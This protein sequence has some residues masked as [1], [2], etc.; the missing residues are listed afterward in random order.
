MPPVPIGNELPVTYPI[1]IRNLGTVA[2]KYTID[3]STLEK[4]NRK[5]HEFTIFK[6]LNPNGTLKPQE[7]SHVY[8]NFNPLEENLYSLDLPI[9]V[10]DIDGEQKDRVVLKIR[11][12]GYHHVDKI[13]K[14]E[15]FYENMP[16]CRAHLSEEA[17]AM[18]AFSMES[19]DFGELEANEPSRRF[20]VLYNIDHTDK[21]SFKFAETGLTY[22]DKLRLEPREGEL[23]PMSHVNIKMSLLPQKN[24]VH[25]EG[26]IQCKIDWLDRDNANA[27]TRSMAAT[28]T[29]ANL[30]DESLFIRIKKRAKMTKIAHAMAA[31]EGETLIENFMHEAMHGIIEDMDLDELLD[32]A[33]LASG[34]LYARSVTNQE[35]PKREILQGHKSVTMSD[36]DFEDLD[37]DEME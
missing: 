34:G 15:Q 16:L 22:C 18:A 6:I 28:T 37:E 13:P 21:C 29:V 36:A 27:D 12:T 23:K 8:V 26:E 4:L 3:L 9:K 17:G 7:T 31:R 11:G 25:F 20:V 2:L 19:I 14:E 10:E 24:P 1:E 35:K 32:N 33:H 5:H 30:N